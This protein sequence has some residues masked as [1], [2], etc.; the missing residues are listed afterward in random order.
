M[1]MLRDDGDDEDEDDDGGKGKPCRS[2]RRRMLTSDDSPR[3]PPSQTRSRRTKTR[4]RIFASGDTRRQTD[5]PLDD[6]ADKEVSTMHACLQ[7]KNT[8]RSII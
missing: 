8:D 6:G 4:S 1:S 3:T 5:S 7:H 2:R